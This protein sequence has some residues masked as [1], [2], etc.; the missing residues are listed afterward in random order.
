MF[1]FSRICLKIKYMHSLLGISILITNPGTHWRRL[2]PQT[3]IPP[4][5]KSETCIWPRRSGLP[6]FRRGCPHPAKPRSSWYRVPSASSSLPRSSWPS[7]LGRRR[8]H[9]HCCCL[10]RCPGP[11]PHQSRRWWCRSSLPRSETST[12][13]IRLRLPP[14]PRSLCRVQFPPWIRRWDPRTGR[15]AGKWLSVGAWWWWCWCHGRQGSELWLKKAYVFK[16][17]GQSCVFWKC[18][19]TCSQENG[20]LNHLGAS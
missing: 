9:T 7:P 20:G 2:L 17:G 13:H 18:I 10:H 12:F 15:L 5:P 11:R 6:R 16:N 3:L 1:T 4:R 14:V 19:P 8:L